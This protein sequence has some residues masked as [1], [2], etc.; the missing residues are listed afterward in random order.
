MTIGTRAV[1]RVRWSPRRGLA[2]GRKAWW[3]ELITI[4]AGY[5]LYELVQ[6]AAPWR[7][8]E[9][10]NH[11]HQLDRLE[12]QLHIDVEPRLNHFVNSHAW[13]AYI[14][15]YWYDSLH[16]LIT[17]SVLLWL[18]LRRP[19]A[20]G[21]YRSGLIIASVGSL[22]VFWTWPLAPPR[23]AI[24]GTVDT[25]YVRHIL[26]SVETHAASSL[27]NDYAA[28]PSLHCGWALW[29]AITIVGTTSSRWHHLAWLYPIGTTLAVMSTGNHYLLDAVGGAAVIT[30]GLLVTV[31]RPPRARRRDAQVPST[32][33]PTGISA[34]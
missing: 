1:A 20:Y 26:G 21:H 27:V 25:L 29:C 23:L 31:S 24:P 30:A 16:Y 7:R 19:A 32:A 28:M 6:G 2:W 18:W 5:A 14:E 4:F 34:R 12:K 22:V 3:I 13:L 33:A 9:A 11:A 15:G 17:P 10:L 8:R